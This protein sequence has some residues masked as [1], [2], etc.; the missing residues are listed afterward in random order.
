MNTGLLESHIRPIV[1][2]SEEEWLQFLSF[3]ESRT[4]RRNDYFLKAGEICES[5]AFV[6]SGVF[7][8]FKFPESG[9]EVTTDFAFKGEWISD[10]QSI[11]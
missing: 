10:N 8:Y 2:L 11:N 7:I 5:T 4:L 9:K 3:T 6:N 1:S